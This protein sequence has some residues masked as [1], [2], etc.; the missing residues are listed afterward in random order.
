[1]DIMKNKKVYAKWNK[2]KKFDNNLIV[3]GGGAAGL[4]S[5]YIAAAVKAKVTLIEANKMGGDCLNYGCVPS[6]ALI[7]SAKLAQEMRNAEHYGLENTEPT[8]SFS[9][10]MT[11]IQ[12]II[13]KIEPHDSVERY[14]ELGVNVLEGYGKLIDH[15]TVEVKLKNG[16]TQTITARSIVIAAGAQ[17][18]VP[19]IPGLDEVNFLTSDTLWDEFEKRDAVPKRLRVLGGGPI[20]CELAQSF[21]RLGSSVSQ[22]EILPRIMIREDEEVSALAKETLEK[23]GVSVLTDNKAVRCE[24][25][26]NKKFIF[27]EHE[28]SEKRIE[29]DDI[30]CAV[31]RVARLTGYGLDDIGVS[32][33]HTVVT[34]V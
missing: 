17:P 16:E 27:L 19:P 13:K 6:K 9:K 15:W 32:V 23:D 21:A 10:V 11:R 1:V 18:F 33:E 20:G 22:I 3:I 26:D 34:N 30:I 25:I 8:F 31:G 5:A 14:T 29:F 2:P 28:G 12:N 7:R 24:I 4:V